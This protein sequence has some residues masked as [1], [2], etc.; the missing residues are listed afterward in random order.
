M[1]SIKYAYRFVIENRIIDNNLDYVT[2]EQWLEKPE[3]TNFDIVRD[4]RMEGEYEKGT[5][6]ETHDILWF[7]RTTTEYVGAFTGE[8]RHRIIN[9]SYE[10]VLQSH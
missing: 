7:G 1:S 3:N 9:Y 4:T 2:D 6:T 8:V 10:Y 5:V